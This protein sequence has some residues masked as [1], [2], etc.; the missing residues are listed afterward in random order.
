MAFVSRL[1]ISGGAAFVLAPA[2]IFSSGCGKESPSEPKATQTHPSTLPSGSVQ[3][4][5]PAKT[6]AGFEAEA[7][8]PTKAKLSQAYEYWWE[9]DGEKKG[10]Y[11]VQLVARISYRGGKL[12]L[13][14]ADTQLLTSY[15][16]KGKK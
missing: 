6:T 9:A 4:I 11:L 12:T 13:T 14:D 8:D 7:I 2:L 15:K 1:T 16:I 3:P 5:E 10:I